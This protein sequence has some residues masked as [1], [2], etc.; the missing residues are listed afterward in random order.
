MIHV[1]GQ[2]ELDYVFWS[3]VFSILISS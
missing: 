1:A 3:L 2:D